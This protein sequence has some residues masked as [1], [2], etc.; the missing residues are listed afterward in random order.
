MTRTLPPQF[1]DLQQHADRWVVDSIDER[2]ALRGTTPMAEIR[3]FYDAAIVRAD[4]MLAYLEPMPLDEID[5]EAACALKLLLG[6]AQASISI[7]IQGQPLPPKTTHPLG[8]HLISGVT[9]FGEPVSE[10]AA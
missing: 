4:E 3:N 7:E 2:V 10:T 6:L 9:P 8:V 1:A 5:G